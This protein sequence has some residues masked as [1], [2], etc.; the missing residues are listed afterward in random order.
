MWPLPTSVVRVVSDTLLGVT[1]DVVWGV[2]DVCGGL[3]SLVP[4][5]TEDD[6]EAEC[7][8][9]AVCKCPGSEFGSCV[10]V[11]V[12]FVDVL[13]TGVRAIRLGVTCAVGLFLSRLLSNWLFAAGMSGTRLG[14]V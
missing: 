9:F 14:V 8:A 13:T 4:A 7:I 3:V 5:S 6:E 12:L 2:V 10:V 11:V 1:L